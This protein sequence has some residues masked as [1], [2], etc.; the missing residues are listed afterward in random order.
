MRKILAT[1]L[2]LVSSTAFAEVYVRANAGSIESRTPTSSGAY[3][4]SS[5]TDYSRVAIGYKFEGSPFAV[6]VGKSNNWSQSFS[7]GTPGFGS[8]ISFTYKD[9]VDYSV[10]AYVY[11]GLYAKAGFLDAT[12]TQTGVSQFNG[13]TTVKTY[14]QARPLFG[15]GYD[16]EVWK[17]ADINVEIV[18]M[19]NV[20]SNTNVNPYVVSAGVKFKY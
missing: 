3:G 19:V 18:Q 6:E 8:D 13:T 4:V 17:H 15:V 1:L 2:L 10:L 7:T 9:A 20:G 11:K 12:T 5:T 16:Y 14:N